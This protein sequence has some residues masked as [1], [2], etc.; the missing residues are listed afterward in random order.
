MDARPFVLLPD[1]TVLNMMNIQTMVRS[2]A[3][4]TITFT[5]GVTT[6]VTSYC[7]DAEAARIQHLI[8]NSLKPF[9]SA[10]LAQMLYGSTSKILEVSPTAV[11]I[12]NTAIVTGVG[13]HSTGSWKYGST[14]VLVATY[15][16]DATWQITIP[17]GEPNGAVDLLFIEGGS[18]IDTK[19]AAFTQS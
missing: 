19:T 5:D 16:N 11:S 15:Y 1:G 18:T 10:D 9:M 3:Q 6:S 8:I 14:V 4:I 7:N 13:L 17:T 2:A 12:G